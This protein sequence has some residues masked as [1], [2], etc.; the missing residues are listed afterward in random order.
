MAFLGQR[1]AEPDFKIYAVSPALYHGGL[2]SPHRPV[3]RDPV[4]ES[5]AH[6]RCL[7]S[8][9]PSIRPDAEHLLWAPDQ[10]APESL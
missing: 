3:L 1:Q 9:F 4:L 6:S 5:S 2:G 8:Q 7:I 10:C